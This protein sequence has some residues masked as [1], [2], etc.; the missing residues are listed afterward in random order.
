MKPLDEGL[1]FISRAAHFLRAQS[2]LNTMP[3][4]KTQAGSTPRGRG[5]WCGH[6]QE[7]TQAPR[8]AQEQGEPRKAAERGPQELRY[9]GAAGPDAD[10]APG[11]HPDPRSI[12]GRNMRLAHDSEPEIGLNT[13]VEFL[14]GRKARMNGHFR[15]REAPGEANSPKNVGAISGGGPVRD[16]CPSERRG[17]PHYF[18]KGLTEAPCAHRPGTPQ[19]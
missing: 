7:G 3:H 9:D 1:R 15:P 8:P 2:N 6:G 12:W 11:G 16:Q 17:E 5:L 19:R 14:V 4:P 10:S 13:S 18:S